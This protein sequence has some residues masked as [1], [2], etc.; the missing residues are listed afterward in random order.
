MNEEF[1]QEQITDLKAQLTASLERERELR[2][3]VEEA[4][5]L[6]PE[7]T[8]DAESFVAHLRKFV[9]MEAVVSS[10]REWRD[11]EAAALF[12]PTRSIADDNERVVRMHQS[13]SRL[14]AALDALDEVGGSS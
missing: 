3:E 12:D 2:A 10:A 1:F 4:R 5:A 13:N 9:A 11:D 7:L 6:I 14:L 8:Q